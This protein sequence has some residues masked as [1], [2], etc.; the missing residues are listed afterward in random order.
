MAGRTP[1]ARQDC[2]RR[3]LAAARSKL[4]RNGNATIVL[5]VLSA[6][7]SLR[8]EDEVTPYQTLAPVVNVPLCQ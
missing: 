8:P 4:P 2:A 5:L 1:E 6:A 3:I 7:S